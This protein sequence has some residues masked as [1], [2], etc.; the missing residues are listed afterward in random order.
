M[1]Y[2]PWACQERSTSEP[3]DVMASLPMSTLVMILLAALTARAI[4]PRG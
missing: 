2:G 4:L 1:G 3:G